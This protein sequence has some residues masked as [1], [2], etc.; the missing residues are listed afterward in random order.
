MKRATTRTNPDA[1]CLV[2]IRVGA[3][4]DAGWSTWFEGLSVNP[5]SGGETRLS[6]RVR[7]QA[8]L[9]GLLARLWDLG[10]PLLSLEVEDRAGSM[11]DLASDTSLRLPGSDAQPRE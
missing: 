1:G 4:L 11:S 3:S 10:V 2:E 7:D 5:L 9:R 6:G 8:A